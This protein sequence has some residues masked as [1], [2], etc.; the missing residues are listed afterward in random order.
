MK[1]FYSPLVT[2]ASIEGFFQLHFLSEDDVSRMVLCGCSVRVDVDACALVVVQESFQNKRLNP[3]VV[4]E[5]RSGLLSALVSLFGLFAAS[6]TTPTFVQLSMAKSS[7]FFHKLLLL[8]DLTLFNIKFPP[9][10]FLLFYQ[11]LF[12]HH[13]LFFDYLHLGFQDSYTSAGR[14][15]CRK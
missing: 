4:G 3:S 14:L 13:H 6:L 15:A 5:R 9:F 7:L 10:Q 11:L 1:V 2:H 8:P 12:L